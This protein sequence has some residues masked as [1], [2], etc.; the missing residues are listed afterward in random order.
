MTRIQGQNLFDEISLVMIKDFHI[1]IVKQVQVHFISIVANRSNKR[2]RLIKRLD[3]PVQRVGFEFRPCNHEI[4]IGKKPIAL[5]LR[6]P[7]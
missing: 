2:T 6:P 5:K 3:L 4:N 7:R 1:A